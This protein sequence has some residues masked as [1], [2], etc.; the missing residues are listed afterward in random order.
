M[1]FGVL[2][3]TSA[4][5]VGSGQDTRDAR[6][7]IKPRVQPDNLRTLGGINLRLDANL[8]LIPVVVTDRRDRLVL[9]LQREHFRLYDNQV[10]Q[11]ITH[12]AMQD[13]PVS[14]GIVFDT[15]WSMGPK[16]K[17]S[18]DAVGEI[19][20]TAN[21]EDEFALIRFNG[22]VE[23]A[24][25][26]RDPNE[27]IQNRLMFIESKGQT[28]LLDAI[29]FALSEM[30]SARHQRKAIVII[31]DGGDNCS[32]YSLKEVMSLVREAEVQIFAVAILE[33]PGLRNRTPEEFSGPGLLSDLA[34]ETGGRM[35][36]SE[37]NNLRSIAAEISKT[38]RNQ[39]LIGYSPRDIENDGKYHRVQVQ[40]EGIG[41]LRLSWRLGYFAPS[42]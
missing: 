13:A 32:R 35:F 2:L 24:K 15:S 34:I 20:K 28:A 27:Y 31:S 19:L 33:P 16:L 1:A 8:V 26:F 17:K 14:V 10:E 9:G 21:P 42:R 38:L 18:R 30:R 40:V 22:Q 12:F 29:Y 4:L 6:V 5:A 7:S 25:G 37:S 41:G 11:R 39:Y 36:A 23:L 3:G